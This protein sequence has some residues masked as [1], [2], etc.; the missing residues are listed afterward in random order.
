MSWPDGVDAAWVTARA[1]E[2]QGLAD[3]VRR[4]AHAARTT[5][6]VEWRSGGGE[7]FRAALESDVR[8]LAGVAAAL[9]DVAAALATHARALDHLEHGPAQVAGL[10]L[11][12]AQWLS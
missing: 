3:D 1:A 8:A 10:A 5:D 11:R 12:M 6:G 9:D 4:L 7:A 2:V